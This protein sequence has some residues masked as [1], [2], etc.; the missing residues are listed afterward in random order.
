MIPTTSASC[1][2][3]PRM[4]LEMK[5]VLPLE[6][7]CRS[8]ARMATMPAGSRPLAGSSRRSSR[9]SLS[10]APAMPEPLLHPERVAGDLVPRPLPQP[11]E[12]EQLLDP[13]PGHVRRRWPPARAGSRDPT[14]TD[15]TTAT[16]SAPR[17]RTGDVGRVRRT[18]DQGARSCPRPA[19][20][21][22]SAGASSWSCPR[23]WAPGSRT[24]RRPA[25]TAPAR[26]APR[27]SRSASGVRAWQG[28]GP[29]PES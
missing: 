25:R 9:G 5:T 29:Y 19:G 21:D 12:L 2:T 1:W 28:P 4:W 13:G 8:V 6:A 22:R 14:G 7:R 18:A 10:S 15:R 27:A 3:S 17:R 20:S 26:R 24:P 23:R 11:D 16:R